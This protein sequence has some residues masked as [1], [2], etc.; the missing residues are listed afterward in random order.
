MKKVTISDISRF[1][2]VFSYRLFVGKRF[3]DYKDTLVSSKYLYMNFLF[4]LGIGFFTGAGI[5]LSY[6][7]SQLVFF[8]FGLAVVSFLS[9][10]FLRLKIPLNV[11]GFFF[12]ILFGFFCAYIV[13]LG[14]ANGFASLW[15]FIFPIIS[16]LFL[17][18][19][20]GI[21]I[22]II[23]GSVISTIIFNPE[24]SRHQY[25]SVGAGIFFS[26]YVLLALITIT[27]EFIRVSKEDE[28]YQ[29]TVDLQ[30]ERDELTTM[31]DNLNVGIFLID[32]NL[33]I[34]PYYSQSLEDILSHSNLTGISFLDVFVDSI[35]V[36]QRN[37]L[38][39]YFTMMF[40]MTYNVKLLEE[41]NPLNEIN[42]V[43]AETRA[44][45]ILNCKF[46]CIQRQDESLLLGTI[47]DI[48]EQVKTG[49]QLKEESDK[50]QAEMK[51]LFEIIQIEPA[52]FDEFI[53]DTDYQFDRLNKVLKRRDIPLE[54][55]VVNFYQSIHA[56]K[57]NAA[58]LGLE[59]FA[60]KCHAMEEEVKN[61]Q[62]KPEM[63]FDDL[64]HLTFEL[65]KLFGERD[66]LE[67]TLDRITSF[68][69]EHSSESVFV[70]SVRKALDKVGEE[71]GKQVVLNAEGID[72]DIIKSYLRNI[73]K[74]IVLQFARNAVYHGIETPDV[75]ESLQKAPNG[76]ITLSITKKDDIVEV[77]FADDGK[78]INLDSI[79][80][81]AL[82]ANLIPSNANK[83]QILSAMFMPG[84]STSKEETMSAGRG[85]G[86]SLVAE[87]LK[88]VNGKLSISTKEGVG[89]TF[90]LHIPYHPEG[91]AHAEDSQDV[92]KIP[93]RKSVSSSLA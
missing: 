60:E 58:I 27:S 46:T 18:I 48:T 29:L 89:T 41:V 17:G 88:E 9:L 91:S 25:D 76:T 4:L 71:T 7:S 65:E 28:V 15:C 72:D 75:R 83:N 87:R 67:Q 69:K 59:G 26:V 31:K 39:D 80:E 70:V 62:N 19:R 24:L 16:I 53:E 30:Q 50:R 66:K 6:N 3:S 10:L 51:V 56:I 37:T 35:T 12:I 82:N 32:Q 34:Q 11:S 47:Y 42:Y 68:R 22:D 64:L 74:E 38:K 92:E 57:S 36:M 45:R 33:I 78:G 5:V 23:M 40:N 8:I 77:I 21:Y 49:R 63:K 55:V 52:V 81:K 1:I 73:L 14:F 93:V 61:I 85:I 20:Y 13:H 79:K 90:T 86:L 84:L 43:S 54:E 2:S 44:K